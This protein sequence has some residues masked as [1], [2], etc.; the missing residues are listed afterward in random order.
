MSAS[1]TSINAPNSNMLPSNIGQNNGRH[2]SPARS[3]KSIQQQKHRRVSSPTQSVKSAQIRRVT[4]PAPNNKNNHQYHRAESPAT[5]IKSRKSQISRSNHNQ[6]QRNVVTVPQH[7]H[8][9]T[10]ESS[11]EE[12]FS[13][14]QNDEQ[15]VDNDSEKYPD[16]ETELPPPK[17]VVPTHQWE[18]E[19]CTY[20]NHAGTRVC[21]ICCKTPTGLPQRPSTDSQQQQQQ[22]QQQHPRRLRRNNSDN[23]RTTNSL[24]TQTRSQKNVSSG[25]S[26]RRGSVKSTNSRSDADYNDTDT[27]RQWHHSEFMAKRELQPTSDDYSDIPYDEGYVLAQFNKQLRITHKSDKSVD[28][29]EDPYEGVHLRSSDVESTNSK[30]KGRPSRKISFWPGTKFPQKC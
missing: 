7:T 28:A 18:C 3:T 5:S 8:H 17:P 25:T 14:V 1:Q 21:A 16:E 10:S 6:T 13:N 27:S 20:V 22:Q 12:Y 23:S 4:S 26:F 29:E 30:R 15:E 2:S 19:H 11:G 24:N 9:D